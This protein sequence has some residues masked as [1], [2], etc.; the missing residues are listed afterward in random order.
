ME[1]VMRA[2]QQL[3]PITLEEMDGVKLM[4][5]T[6]TKY[7]FNISR[8][9]DFLAEVSSTYRVLEVNNCRCSRYETVYFDTTDFSL[10]TKHHNGKLNRYK[11][12]CRKYVESELYFF[13][14]KYKNNKGRT[15]KDRVK[16][17]EF[18]LGPISDKPYDLIKKKTPLV[19]ENLFP[20]IWVNYSRI[21]L[22]N[23]FSK[24]R[25]TIDT[26]LNVKNDSKEMIFPGL[27]I[28]EVKQEKAQPSP[29][30]GVMKKAGIREGS[31]SKYCF[32]VASLYD[33]VKKNSF[34]HKIKT[35]NKIAL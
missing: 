5:R 21:T 16:N 10:Y 9:P 35:I 13:E 25:L 7:V 32:G 12:R 29:F 2:L 20:N 24:E 34:K 22:V 31:I 6:D 18:V 26:M 30:I 8:L 28:A 14:V 4:D 11:V 33:N 17:K 19:P 1:S 23:N 15:I 27:V 3:Q